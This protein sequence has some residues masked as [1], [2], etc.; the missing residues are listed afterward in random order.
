MMKGLKQTLVSP[1]LLTVLMI[2]V[3]PLQAKKIN[4]FE[5]N[6]NMLI[7]ASE[8]HSGGPD[9]DGI[10]SIDKPRFILAANAGLK[11]D[12]IVLGLEYQGEVKAYPLAIMNWHEIVNDQFSR[13]PVVV[14]YCPLCGSGVAYTAWAKGL[15]LEFG[16]SGLLYNSDVLLY[17]RQTESLWSQL[18]S[19]SVSGPMAGTPL[20]M[21]PLIQISWQ[22]WLD[23]HPDT[24]VL[25][26][27]TGFERDYS[28]DPYAGYEDSEGVWF[29]VK[30]KDPRYHPKE[31]VLGVVFDG[32]AKAY[33]MAEITSV[34]SS[35]KDSFAGRELTINYNPETGS[36][37]IT[38]HDGEKVAAV[39]SFWFAW[40][41]FHPKTEVY[42]APR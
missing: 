20:K 33:P 42:T 23:Q 14:T 24:L 21:L 9:R 26:R 7:P 17:D 28:K 22:E 1:L 41:A 15:N 16:V 29:P 19:K 32:L 6:E 38:Q 12:D 13:Q 18:L 30:N 3:T 39:N 31:R 5:L 11:K 2:A 8:V 36:A 40:Y 37:F 25:S 35:F 34:N 4:G 27:D 10:P